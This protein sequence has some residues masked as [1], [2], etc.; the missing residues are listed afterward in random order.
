L[1]TDEAIFDVVMRACTAQ[2]LDPDA[3]GGGIIGRAV[4]VV[5]ALG[6]DG[7][8]PLSSLKQKNPS[9]L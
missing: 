2:A 5:K 3:N 8:L 1:K 6:L 4:A 9:D 7:D